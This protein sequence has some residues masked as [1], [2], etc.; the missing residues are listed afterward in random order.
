MSLA[1]GTDKWTAIHERMASITKLIEQA[2]SPPPEKAARILAER[3]RNLALEPMIQ[4]ETADHLRLVEFLLA[5]ENYGIETL[6]VREIYPLVEFTPLPGTPPFVLGIANV[7]GQIVSVIDIKR[8]FDLPQ[9]G[10]TN[11]NQL[12]VVRSQE[13]ELGILADEV[14]GVRSIGLEDL[15]PPLPTMTGIRG[16][17][18]RGISAERLAVLDIERIL[19]DRRIQVGTKKG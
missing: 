17:F 8:F 12:I 3:A 4:K 15:Q 14:L 16:E 10:L 18:L 13:I 9:K 2:S 11:L 6:Y 7:R 19:G 5:Y 1:Q